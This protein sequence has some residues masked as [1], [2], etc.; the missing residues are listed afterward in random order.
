LRNYQSPN[1]RENPLRVESAVR[2][3]IAITGER[4]SGRRAVADWLR[5]TFEIEKPRPKYFS[6]GLLSEADFLAEASTMRRR[7]KS[8]SPWPR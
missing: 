7:T 2:K 3:L 6:G 5:V 4:Q 1:I 8:P